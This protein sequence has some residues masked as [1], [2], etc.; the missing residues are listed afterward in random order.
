M[1]VDDPAHRG[2]DRRRDAQLPQRPARPARSHKALTRSA[3]RYVGGFAT[4]PPRRAA[5]RRRRRQPPPE[6]GLGDAEG[7]LNAQFGTGVTTLGGV[8]TNDDHTR[9]AVRRP[10]W[11]TLRERR[12]PTGTSHVVR[13]AGRGALPRPGGQPPTA[14]RSSRA[15]RPRRSTSVVANLVWSEA[16]LG[17]AAVV[18][19]VG[20]RPAARAPPAP[21]AARGRRH[22]PA[23]DRAAAGQRRDRHHGAGPRR[24]HRR[25]HR[26][27]RRSVPR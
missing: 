6:F 3:G 9:R 21:A 20:A 11:R 17:L 27:R 25:A 8:V 24:P 1:L 26:G 7:T 14:S 16:L 13:P 22:R 10:R 23:G 15:S 2:R 18:V 4:P 19:A 12:R 5:R